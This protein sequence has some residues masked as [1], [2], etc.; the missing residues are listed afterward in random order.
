MRAH[1]TDLRRSI[2]RLLR[3]RPGWSFQ[4][5]STPGSP[6]VWCFA[7]GGAITLS[8]TVDGNVICVHLFAMDQDTELR[9]TEELVEWLTTHMDGALQEPKARLVD[10]FK[11]GRIF[12][13]E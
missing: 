6:L 3:R 5:T 11:S 1:D 8:V 2:D 9:S 10:K 12:K 7:S 4:A 13:W